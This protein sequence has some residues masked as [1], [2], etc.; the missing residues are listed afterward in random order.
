VLA[1]T[2]DTFPA[3]LITR[4]FVSGQNPESARPPC[5][6]V[7]L[8]MIIEKGKLG[9]QSRVLDFVY[10]SIPESHVHP[11]AGM[12]PISITRDGR[13]YPLTSLVLLLKPWF[14]LPSCLEV[15]LS[16][17]FLIFWYVTSFG[18]T[19]AHRPCSESCSGGVL[20]LEDAIPGEREQA[21]VG[22]VTVPKPG[23]TRGN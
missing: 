5:F 15:C 1:Y 7:C 9:E 16:Q 13:R 23:R 2:Y 17:L 20:A 12:V 10:R 8:P 18:S 22:N 3:P 19:I 14:C 11:N 21:T 6:Y 4:L